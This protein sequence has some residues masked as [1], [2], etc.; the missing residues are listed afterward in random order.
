MCGEG[1]CWEVK[2]LLFLRRKVIKVIVLML[3][4][5][6]IVFIMFFLCI[7]FYESGNINMGV[8]IV[9]LLEDIILNES[10]GNG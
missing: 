10:M 7:D 9:I 3:Q 2:G 1:S 5:E 6:V 8:K 4:N